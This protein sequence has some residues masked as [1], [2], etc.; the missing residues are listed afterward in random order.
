MEWIDIA[1][2]LIEWK[3]ASL[4]P[5]D[6]SLPDPAAA[7]AQSLRLELKTL[8]EDQ[9]REASAFLAGR[10]AQGENA[11]HSSR[12]NPPPSL[13]GDD[14]DTASLWTMRSK[15]R[16]LRDLF[17]HRRKS[18]QQFYELDL[19]APSVEEMKAIVVGRLETLPPGRWFSSA[20]WFDDAGSRERRICL[21]LAILD[22]AAAGTLRVADGAT[23]ECVN[24]F[25]CA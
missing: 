7:I 3:S 15:A 1:A 13:P 8:S 16:T 20:R 11:S 9:L 10:S 12:H 18:R 6:P 17:H 2:R 21:F 25:R 4:L 22:L 23:P 14:D 24:L 19:S 5:A